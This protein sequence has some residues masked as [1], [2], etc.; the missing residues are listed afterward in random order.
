MKLHEVDCDGMLSL[1]SPLPSA[2]FFDQ[3]LYTRP[4]MG[5]Q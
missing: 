2:P 3:A 1:A 5:G 4:C